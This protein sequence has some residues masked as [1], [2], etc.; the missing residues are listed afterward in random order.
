MRVLKSID[1]RLLN[2]LSEIAALSPRRRANHNLHLRLDDPVQRLLNAIEPDT[3][4][5]P[6]RHAEPAT[7]EIIS[8]V[9]GAAVVLVFN[10]DGT[11]LERLDLAADGPVRGAEVPPGAWH[12]IASLEP[13]TVFF[14]VKQ[15]P[16][17]PPQ[18]IHVASWAPAEGDPDVPRFRS[19]YRSARP[20]DA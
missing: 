8:L 1:D 7:F 19:W 17:A 4:I 3:Y 12:T 11:V 14:E 6:Q 9:R 2:E 5:R 18:G 20:G 10:D 15:G 13:G 16:Y